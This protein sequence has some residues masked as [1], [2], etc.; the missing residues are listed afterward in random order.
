MKILVLSHT[1]PKWQKFEFHWSQSKKSFP[2][3][4]LQTQYFLIIGSLEDIKLFFNSDGQ[5]FQSFVH[6]D[7]NLTP[8][9]FFSFQAQKNVY[10]VFSDWANPSLETKILSALEAHQIESQ[11]ILLE[12]T[13]KDESRKLELKKLELENRVEKRQNFLLESRRKAFVAHTRLEV[14]KQIILLLQQSK[15]FS[16]MESQIYSILKTTHHLD[17]VRILLAPQD[18]NFIKKLE[19][20]SPWESAINSLFIGEKKLGSVIFLREKGMLFLKQ[21]Q[22]LFTALAESL[23][24]VV[25]RLIKYEQASTLQ[26]QWQGTFN[27]MKSPAIVVN[28][29]Y[30]IIQMNSSAESW[31]AESAK[32]SIKDRICYQ[33][34]FGRNTPCLGCKMGFEFSVLQNKNYIEVKSASINENSFF[35]IYTDRTENRELEG[36][37]LQNAKLADL[38][39]IGSSLAHELNNPL[40]AVSSFTQL[41]LM[42]LPESSPW[43]SDLEEIK[44]GVN[45][46]QEIIDTLLLFTFTSPNEKKE[47]FDFEKLLQ[48]II[49]LLELKSRPRGLMIQFKPVLTKPVLIHGTESA[50]FQA[51]KPLIQNAVERLL[52]EMTS[53]PGFKPKLEIELRDQDSK[54][55]F[56]ILDNS[57]EK[58]LHLEESYTLL[59]SA[60]LELVA[61][62][63]CKVLNS[64]RAKGLKVLKIQLPSLDLPQIFD[65]TVKNK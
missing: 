65:S 38:G 54:A 11:E 29:Q 47:T 64:E 61:Q 60:A 41:A 35:H 46:S 9:D 33:T 43:R 18:D 17:S 44:K 53:E 48:K 39:L 26:R 49:S 30:K 6:I 50:Y 63:N 1:L 5:A 42:D 13:L 7:K 34:L 14:L 10:A 59:Y 36:R 58:N 15:S 40:A 3:E 19:K 57:S 55:T 37:I 25:S 23:S 51:F 27:S 4:I 28:S 20:A 12:N 16:E 62:L 52:A 2:Q 45:R 31:S 24:L 56:L 8:D 32:N 21:D 22:E